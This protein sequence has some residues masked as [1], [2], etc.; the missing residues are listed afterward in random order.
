MNIADELTPIKDEPNNWINEVTAPPSSLTCT[1]C[2]QKFCTRAELTDHVRDHFKK[3]V[4][5]ICDKELIGDAQYGYHISHAHSIP[6]KPQRSFKCRLCQ[7]RF[8][9]AEL[10]KEHV[11]QN[12]QKVTAERVRTEF[13][14]APVACNFCARIFDTEEAASRHQ[15]MTH[16]NHHKRF[17]CDYCRKGFSRKVQYN[18]KFL[19]FHLFFNFV[20][21]SFLTRG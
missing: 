17:V 1:M 14:E 7:E 21:Y 12:H 6:M 9:S 8:P 10:L 4:C 3:Y 19:L 2:N 16:S 15:L 13:S 18:L 20:Q 5:L 11:T